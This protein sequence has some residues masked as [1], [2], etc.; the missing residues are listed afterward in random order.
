M[1]EKGF[2]KKQSA[3][4]K[5]FGAAGV[6]LALLPICALL[7]LSWTL[8]R[9][10][11]LPAGWLA[12]IIGICA[13]VVA[14]PAVWVNCAKRKGWFAA[15]AVCAVVVAAALLTGNFYVARGVS[16]LNSITTTRGEKS[17][18]NV[19]VMA[20][21]EAQAIADVSGGTFGIMKLLDR[22]NTDEAVRQINENL[23][24]QIALKEYNGFLEQIDAL[25]NG[26]V[27]AI[28]LNSAFLAVAEEQEG[29]EN[30][31]EQLRVLSEYTAVVAEEPQ[32]EEPVEEVKQ[33]APVFTL[34]FSG[35]KSESDIMARVRS[36]VNILAAINAETRQVALVSMPK[37]AYVD[38]HNTGDAQDHLG[39]AAIY[40]IQVS[41]DT[42]QKLYGTNVDY[43]FRVNFAGFEDVI[44]ALGGIT[45]QSDYTFNTRWNGR[46]YHYE[47]GENTLDGKQALWFVH[48]KNAFPDGEIQRGRNQMEVIRAVMNKMMSSAFL[49]NYSAVL[50]SMN[51]CFVSNGTYDLVS[52]LVRLQLS[53]GDDWNVVTYSVTGDKAWKKLHTLNAGA[54]VQ[55]NDEESLAIAAELIED[56]LAGE[57]VTQPKNK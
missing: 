41:M 33:E 46:S 5:G 56:V 42:L 49:K 45:V 52:E 28:V 55:L 51:N 7:L 43:Y 20:D 22:D 11:L 47:K 26:E 50:D 12:G 34:Y 32:A 53:G 15:G 8:I 6:V 37:H 19:Y 4:G 31:S 1:E 29:Y 30:V 10:G 17:L 39:N 48:E 21:S 24:T 40:G 14:I 3:S 23:N 9:S 27:D 2:V 54:T 38:V 57:T 44:D 13:V 35:V 36:D 18:V 16:F 25:R